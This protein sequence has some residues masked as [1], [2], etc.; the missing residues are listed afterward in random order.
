M[1]ELR[2]WQAVRHARVRGPGTTWWAGT[3]A[4]DEAFWGRPGN[5]GERR[6]G[7]KGRPCGA[8]A[9]LRRPGGETP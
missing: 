5:L 3:P 9:L 2:A 6:P 1:A 8:A 4:P 7:E